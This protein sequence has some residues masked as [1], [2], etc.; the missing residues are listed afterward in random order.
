MPTDAWSPSGLNSSL[1]DHIL[2]QSLLSGLSD[3]SRLVRYV[4]FY[5]VSNGLM[6]RIN[7]AIDIDVSKVF[8]QKK[9]L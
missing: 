1:P 4:M 3:Y 9:N 5:R 2:A 7:A 8:G 6:E